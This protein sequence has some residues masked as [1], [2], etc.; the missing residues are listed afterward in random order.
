MTGWPSEFYDAGTTM[1]YL[2]QVTGQ[3][4]EPRATLEHVAKGVAEWTPKLADD[5]R[6]GPDDRDPRPGE[7]Y[8]WA[9]CLVSRA[10]Y[11]HITE[12]LGSV[13]LDRYGPDNRVPIERAHSIVTRV[14]DARRAMVDDII[15]LRDRGQ[16]GTFDDWRSVVDQAIDVIDGA[17]SSANAAYL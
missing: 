9:V 12:A 15:G 13:D 5:R 1:L 10:A 7:F 16:L 6:T 8:F 17:A 14:V 11:G 4:W 3:G 2:Y